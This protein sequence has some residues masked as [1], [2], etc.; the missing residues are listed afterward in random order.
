MFGAALAIIF[1]NKE[2]LLS[3]GS[4]YSASEFIAKKIDD[5]RQEIK[6]ISLPFE[7]IITCINDA[8]IQVS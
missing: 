3:T 6:L 5:K 2:Q 4:I 7:S 8:L 1:E